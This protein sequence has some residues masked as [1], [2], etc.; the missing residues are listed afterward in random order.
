M[1]NLGNHQESPPAVGEILLYW[2]RLKKISQME[3]ALTVDVSSRHLSFVET[4]KSKPS[5]ALI[6]RLAEALSLPFR[7]RNTL[8]RSAGYS[9]EFNNLPFDHSEMG[10]V[11]DALHSILAKHEP[12]PAI[13]MNAAYEI[14]MKNSGFDRMVS[15]SAGE[16]ALQKYT[17]I[18]RLMFAEDGLRPFFK[19]W[20]IIEHFVL[21]RLLEEVMSTQ[22]EALIALYDEII[23]LKTDATPVDLHIENNTPVSC[24]TLE[25]EGESASFFSTVMTFG[26]PINVTTQELRIESLFPVDDYTQQL[27]LPI[28]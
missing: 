6:L 25:K 7:Q 20:P 28:D 4:G 9:A 13:V 12:Y 24:F 26:T 22:N 18:Y 8:L 2:R 5:R 1:L 23:L 14:L 21:A 11:H 3:L 15:W 19:D 27:F 16:A 17:N 10:L